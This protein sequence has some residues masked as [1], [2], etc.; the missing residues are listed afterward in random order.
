[1]K[2][3]FFSTLAAVAISILSASAGEPEKLNLNVGNVEH[4]HIMDN[5]DVVLIQ[6]PHRDNSIVLDQQTSEKLNV[7][8]NAKTLYIGGRAGKSKEKT[9]VY[10]Y[11][12]N[13]KS[14]TVNGNSDVKTSGTLKTGLLD[15]FVEGNTKVHIKTTGTV[16]AHSLNDAEIKVTYLSKAE[17]GKKPY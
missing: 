16:K 6:A 4:I 13:L 12:N 2:R 9:V 8:L 17:P 3:N 14:L 5:I 10:I 15:V 1:M 7:K 11:V